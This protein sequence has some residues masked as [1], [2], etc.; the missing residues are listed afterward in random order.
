MGDRG[1]IKLVYGEKDDEYSPIYLYTH[2]GGSALP[3]TL[4]G[5]LERGR[6]RWDDPS[7]LARIIFSEM[8]KEEGLLD[9][10]TGYGISP[11]ETDN[12]NDIVTVRLDKGTVQ[13]GEGEEVAF[14]DFVKGQLARKKG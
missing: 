8:I 5:A 6:E 9:S 7:Y 2:W 13:V 4:A 11:Y 14:E 3:G 1:N 10:L 12:E